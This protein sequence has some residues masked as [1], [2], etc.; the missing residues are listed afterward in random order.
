V[1]KFNSGFLSFLR[2][3]V[4]LFDRTSLDKAFL[5]ALVVEHKV[6]I[7]PRNPPSQCLATTTYVANPSPG[8]PWCTFHR[9]STHSTTDFRAIKYN[10]T[11]KALYLNTTSP[12]VHTPENTDPI[13]LPNPTEPDPSLLLMTSASSETQPPTLFTHNC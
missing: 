5:K 10:R 4:E 11:Q 9:T 6:V 3:E 2:K 12:S 13:T 8:M 1:V 7:R